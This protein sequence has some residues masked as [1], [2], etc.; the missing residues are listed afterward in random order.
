MKLG[1][2]SILERTLEIVYQSECLQ[3]EDDPQHQ[4]LREGSM[5]GAVF[6]LSFMGAG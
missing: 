4:T 6:D 1:R 2:Q 3:A 5:R